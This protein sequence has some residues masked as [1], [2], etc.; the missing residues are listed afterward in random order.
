VR[1]AGSCY[2][3]SSYRK[4]IHHACRKAGIEPWNPNQLR[5]TH[6]TEVRRVFGIA[7]LEDAG[8]EAARETLGH[9]DSRTSEIYAKE[10]L[11]RAMLIARRV[12]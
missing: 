12:G 11:E 8:L 5:H 3:E 1:W 10:S 2:T 9:T 7:A 6:G 4:A